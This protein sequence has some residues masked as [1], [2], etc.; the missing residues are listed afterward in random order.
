[1]TLYLFISY[2]VTKIIHD[3]LELSIEIIAAILTNHSVFKSEVTLF[4]SI[5]ITNEAGESGANVINLD[6][7]FNTQNFFYIVS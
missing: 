7:I 4:C 2:P 5:I 6:E 3:Y 1:M